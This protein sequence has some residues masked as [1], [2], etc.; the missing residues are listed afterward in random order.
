MAREILPSD[1]EEMHVE[2]L[3][4]GLCSDKKPVHN[5]C[6][7]FAFDARFMKRRRDRNETKQQQ[8]VGIAGKH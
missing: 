8:Q 4:P 5:E 6:R 3:I 1:G 2:G 7:R